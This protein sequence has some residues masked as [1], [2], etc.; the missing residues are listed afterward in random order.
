MRI[1]RFIG[2]LAILG[3]VWVV[4]GLL[5]S[6]MYPAASRMDAYAG[7]RIRRECGWESNCKVRASDLF[8]G[9]WDTVY[10]FDS[11][12]TQQELDSIF[13]PG[14]VR[15]GDSERL[16]VLEIGKHVVRAER[17]AGKTGK[18]IDGEIKFEDEDHRPQRVVRYDRDQWL[19]VV[20]FPIEPSGRFYVLTPTDEH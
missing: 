9:T 4:G 2:L 7:S 14:S 3:V 5:W 15:V 16:V 18:P 11:G 1:F 6:L 17:A 13:G 12:V 8:E 20:G 19:R 10:I